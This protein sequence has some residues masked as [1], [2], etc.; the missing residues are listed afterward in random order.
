M[1]I[2]STRNTRSTKIDPGGLL[3]PPTQRQI[4]ARIK[5][6]DRILLTGLLTPEL[7]KSLLAEKARLENA[8]L[9]GAKGPSAR[10]TPA[11][12]APPCQAKL[13]ARLKELKSLQLTGFLSPA[14]DRQVKREIAMIEK[15]LRAA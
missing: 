5:T 13:E 10:P 11:L 15:L 6:I 9:A 4:E 12:L 2:S 8:L 7:E 1:Q 14:L 3:A